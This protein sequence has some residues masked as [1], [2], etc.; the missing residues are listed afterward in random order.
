M[1]PI[2]AFAGRYF[3]AVCK[4]KAVRWPIPPSGTLALVLI[5]LV[6]VPEAVRAEAWQGRFSIRVLS[7]RTAPILF[8]GKIFQSGSRVRIEPDGSK[9][10]ALYDFERT[11]KF[12]IFPEDQIY[13]K[14]VLSIADG[15]KA[16]K[17]GWSGPP[18]L[19]ISE[20]I[21][22]RRG[23][24]EEKAARLYLVILQREGKQAYS[25]RWVSDDAREGVLRVVY[26]GPADETVIVDYD[27]ASGEI[28]PEDFFDPPADYLGLN[29][30]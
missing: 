18:A 25:L 6:C 11:L 14:T 23:R 19:Y 21:L 28:P 17:E 1:P 24:F 5:L 27:H 9:E 29:P 30:F 13:F 12:R 3:K 22:L 16:A 20:K 2:S 10:I 8:S 26:P 15:I 7:P 4:G